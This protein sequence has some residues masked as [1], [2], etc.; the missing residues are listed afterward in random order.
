MFT[1]SKNKTILLFCDLQG[2]FE[3]MPFLH[4]I[5]FISI[6]AVMCVAI[7]GFSGYVLLKGF[8]KSKTLRK[9]NNSFVLS[10]VISDMLF[11]VGFI[12]LLIAELCTG[13]SVDRDNSKLC[14]IKSWRVTIFTYLFS[15]RILSVFC[16]SLNT[17]IKTCKTKTRME[18]LY[19]KSIRWIFG[20]GIWTVTPIVIVSVALSGIMSFKIVGTVIIA[21]FLSSIFW[22]IMFYSFSF[23][24]IKRAHQRAD[25]PLYLEAIGFMKGIVGW[26][27]I[28]T[29]PLGICGLT[30]VILAYQDLREPAT[31]HYLYLTCVLITIFD[32]VANP[33]VYLRKFREFQETAPFKFAETMHD[34]FVDTVKKVGD[35]VQEGVR[36][37]SEYIEIHINHH[38]S[39]DDSKKSL[40][41]LTNCDFQAKHLKIARQ[42]KETS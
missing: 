33:I 34:D 12:P 35:K 23:Y 25:S 40:Q 27:L 8:I 2:H 10:L 3:E 9:K 7:I 19:D 28:T 18:E 14:N 22:I 39:D 16:I 42:E 20:I 29:V 30:L 31:E 15:A 41:A 26:F 1:F 13:L 4:T 6:L 17:Y 5:M 38:D 32:A 11:G 24:A 37:I 21:Y 36:P